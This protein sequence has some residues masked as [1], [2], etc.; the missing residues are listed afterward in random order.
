TFNLNVEQVEAAITPRTKAI[1]PVHLYGQAADLDPLL[2]LAEARGLKVLEDV[3]QAFS[4][5]YKGR[6]LGTLGHAAAFSFFPSKNLGAFGD[7]GMLATDDDEIARTA[8]M[9]RVHGAHRKY[10]NETV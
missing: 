7:A 6:K 4:G 10:H 9:L 5:A 3:A 1:L 8:G 2:A